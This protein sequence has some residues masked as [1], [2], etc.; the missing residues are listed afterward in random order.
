[1]LLTEEIKRYAL[2]LG[3]SRVGITTA[4]PFPMYA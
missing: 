1:M 4:D 2:D 3:Y